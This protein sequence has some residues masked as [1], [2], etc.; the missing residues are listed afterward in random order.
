MQAHLP[1]Y[2]MK[3][4]AV[5]VQDPV[6]PLHLLVW[7]LVVVLQHLGSAETREKVV[8]AAS[9]CLEPGPG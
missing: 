8:L 6:Q 7:K 2:L 4:Q 9:A 5:D 1:H 3:A